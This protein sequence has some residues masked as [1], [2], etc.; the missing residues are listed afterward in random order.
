MNW[1]K[2]GGYGLLLWLVMFAVV[3][4]FVGFKIYDNVLMKV[5]TAVIAGAISWVLASYV[6]PT[7]INL[8]IS[9]G[10]SWVVVGVILDAVVTRQFNGQIFLSKGLWLGYLLVLLAPLLRVKKSTPA[11]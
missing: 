3:S 9:Y 6:K 1:Q 4:T 10:F 2:A 5:V 11:V 7:S 8:A